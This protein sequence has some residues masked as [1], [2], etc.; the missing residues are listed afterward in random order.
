MGLGESQEGGSVKRKMGEERWRPKTFIRS[1][2]AGGDSKE[3]GRVWALQAWC[4][5][6]EHGASS[7]L[8]I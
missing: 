5:S 7:S 6:S 2:S 4:R 8:S 3:I 1:G